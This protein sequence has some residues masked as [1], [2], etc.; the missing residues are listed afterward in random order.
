MDA[1]RRKILLGT[2]GALAAV[3]LAA[4]AAAGAARASVPLLSI[5]VA[6]TAYHAAGEAAST[7]RP[8]DSLAL[9]REQQNDY[10]PRAI[11][12]RTRSGAKL[13]YV[14]RTDN[15]ALAN[16]MDAGFNVTARVQKILP[17]RRQPDIRLDVFMTL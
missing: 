1:T 11:A 8:G 10:D 12:V 4:R 15:H 14:P 13:G 17:D 6:G 5:Y 3:A 2:G 16:L 9:Q 7:L